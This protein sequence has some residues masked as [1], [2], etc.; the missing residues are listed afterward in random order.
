[1]RT[2]SQNILKHFWG[3]HPKSENNL[4]NWYR[5]MKEKNYH[6]LLEITKNFSKSDAVGSDRIVFNIKG[7]DYRLVTGFNFDFQ[8]CY[9]KFIGTHK[10]YNE[11]DVIVYSGMNYLRF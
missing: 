9:I 7:S 11:I 8:F 2:S 5:K 10:E 1:M 3:Q 6:S 4:K